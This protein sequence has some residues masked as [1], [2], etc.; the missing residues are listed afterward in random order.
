MFAQ[1]L[2]LI[3]TLL[4]PASASS[5]ETQLTRPRVPLRADT[6]RTGQQ[7]YRDAC[8][9][10]HGPNG[11]GAIPELIVF[12]TPVPDF[13]DCRFGPREGD[14][15]WFGVVHDGGP[16]RGFS[17]MMPAFG[18]AL[19]D[20]EIRRVVD[21]LRTFCDQSEWPRGELN[22]PRPQVTEKAFP[23]DE[24][25]Y[26]TVPSLERPFVWEHELVYEKRFGARN[27][28]EVAV[29]FTIAKR[30]NDDWTGGLGDVAVGV[31]RAMYHNLNRGT[32][33]SAAIEAILPTG[34]EDD[35]FGSGTLRFEPF[36]SAG[37]LLPSD[38]FLQFQLGAEIP[39]DRDRATEEGF[40]RGVIGRT[41]TEHRFG[42]IWSPMIEVLGSREFA[43]GENTR[44]D[45]LP[46]FQVS[47]STRQH[48]RANVGVLVPIN[49]TQ[50]RPVRLWFYLLWDTFD[51]PFFAG[52]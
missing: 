23:E 37:Q 42:R 6:L 17:R 21:Y 4:L 24:A 30:A 14:V 19:T 33:L 20:E 18:D 43:S 36:I 27:Q 41:F 31:K 34:D 28:W 44:W 2:L 22:L 25:V 26:T 11:A 7:I 10:C 13:S 51:G 12:E 32:I 5:N 39:T 40:W 35:G 50:D 9:A 15:D 49:D 48:V 3:G 47:L 29:P 45:V 8:A 1:V 38:A 46:Q 16:A 52:W